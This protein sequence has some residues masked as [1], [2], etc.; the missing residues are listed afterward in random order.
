MFY[1]FHNS[2]R[3]TASTVLA[4]VLISITGYLICVPLREEW[5]ERSDFEVVDGWAYQVR[6]PPTF[7]G[8]DM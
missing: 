8:L 6:L 2:V 5:T 3:N 7:D 4:A 1:T